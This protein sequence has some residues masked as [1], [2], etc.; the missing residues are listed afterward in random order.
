M[1]RNRQR[2]T[3]FIAE[4]DDS[5]DQ[6]WAELGLEEQWYQEQADTDLPTDSTQ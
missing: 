5:M 2:I 4:P 6:D 3:D 1:G